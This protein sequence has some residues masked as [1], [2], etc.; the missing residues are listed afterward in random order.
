MW[1]VKGEDVG[2]RGEDVFGTEVMLYQCGWCDGTM[3]GV[4][5]AYDYIQVENQNAV[6]H[7]LIVLRC[8]PMQFS[9]V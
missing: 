6:P 4:R 2:V 8:A 3:S 1:G 9:I 7:I 5:L